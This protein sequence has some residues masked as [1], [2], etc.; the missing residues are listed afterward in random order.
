MTPTRVDLGDGLVL[1]RAEMNGCVAQ[2][3]TP[4]DVEL[5]AE[6]IWTDAVRGVQLVDGDGHRWG[7]E[8][9]A[10]KVGSTT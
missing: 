3:Y 1:W 7:H 2:A 8:Y 4:D 9:M 6:P 10:H 5:K